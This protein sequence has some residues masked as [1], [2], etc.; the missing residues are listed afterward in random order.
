MDFKQQLLEEG[1][2]G[3]FSLNTPDKILDDLASQVIHE[4]DVVKNRHIDNQFVQSVFND[5]VLLQKVNQFFGDKFNLWRSNFF[6][7]KTGSAEV[8]WHHDKHFE[9]G[10]Q[11]I[12]FNDLTSHLSILVAVTDMEAG[13]GVFEYIKGT[14]ISNGLAER[15]SRPFH[16]RSIDNHFINLS[17]SLISNK[18][19]LPLKKG[20]F[21]LFH[22]ALLHRS[23]A[24]NHGNTRI[25]MIGR[26]A[27][28]NLEIPVELADEKSIVPFQ[29]RDCNPNGLI[30]NVL[31]KQAHRKVVLITG[32]SRGI[33]K[34]LAE[35][36]AEANMNVILVARNEQLLKQ[37]CLHINS[38][39]AGIAIYAVADITDEN[40][41]DLAF[42]T[43][44][45]QFGHLDIVI[46]NAG[47]NQRSASL[48]ELT[49]AE[50]QKLYQANVF[51]LMSTCKLAVE[52]LKASGGNII[53]IGSAIGHFGA[54]NNAAYASS[55]SASWGLTQSLAKEVS[56]YN[57]NVNELI[58]GP[59]KTDMNPN[60]KGNMWK[61]PTDI[62]PLA[63]FLANQNI[64]NGATGQSFSLK[65]L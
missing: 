59:V 44:A 53:T 60:A 47:V 42:K 38:K 25:S 31:P 16:L 6:V 11:D 51:G 15:D 22:S 61:N 41:L 56:S 14:H 52:Y 33:G 46:A 34:A 36:F 32:A 28:N 62:V 50:W 20:Q 2:I 5:E 19:T 43:A 23:L 57:I 65:R 39:D 35:G 27:K 40:Q 64:V 8:A 9:N 63:L 45:E 1:L 3:P 49:L 30:S 7:K 55:K 4:F 21:V 17:E 54:A 48:E 58:P 26:L 12:N 18:T 13:G 24:F 37:A 29:H 10:N